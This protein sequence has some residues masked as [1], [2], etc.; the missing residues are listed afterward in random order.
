MCCT[1]RIIPISIRLTRL[2]KCSEQVPVLTRLSSIVA[3]SLHGTEQCSDTCPE[4]PGQTEH[5]QSDTEQ[6]PWTGCVDSTVRGGAGETIVNCD[7]SRY[8]IVK[9]F[10]G[11]VRFIKCVK[12]NKMHVQVVPAVTTQYNHKCSLDCD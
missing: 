1:Y 9:V 3:V 11:E 5:Q 4:P 2:W 6:L 8:A 7:A 12:A 10:C